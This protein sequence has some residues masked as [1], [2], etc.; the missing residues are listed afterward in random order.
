[1]ERAASILPFAPSHQ[2]GVH[3]DT[4]EP[5]RESGA[6]FKFT[7][8]TAPREKRVLHGILG[9]FVVLE[10]TIRNPDEPFT[11]RQKELLK[12]VLL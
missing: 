9:V 6:T 1:V 11:R 12:D 3:D 7:Q 5:S 2:G 10:N 8:V 4:S